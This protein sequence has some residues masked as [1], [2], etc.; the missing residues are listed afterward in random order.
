MDDDDARPDRPQPR[1]GDV[2]EDPS[3]GR[4]GP[5]ADDP[6]EQAFAPDGG[7]A[8]TLEES[9]ADDMDHRFAADEEISDGGAAGAAE[10]R[11]PGQG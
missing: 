3:L 8:E 1:R 4:R 9:T 10:S 11:T 6:E 2:E 7:I 5:G